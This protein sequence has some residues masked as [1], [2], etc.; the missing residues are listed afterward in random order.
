MIEIKS[1]INE[2]GWLEVTWVEGDEQVFCGS[3]SG[4]PEHIKMLRDKAV[5]FNTPL[6]AYE[7][8]ITKVQSEFKMPSVEE[9]N[10]YEQEQKV[11]ECTTYLASTDWVEP[12]LIRHELGL[13]ILAA[14]SEKFVI[15]QKR[16]EAKTFLKSLGV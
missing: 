12:Y 13:E 4:H 6:D 10:A 7:D 3:Y 11:M 8:M 2:N 15:K 1:V 16:D 14:D 5:E 9:L